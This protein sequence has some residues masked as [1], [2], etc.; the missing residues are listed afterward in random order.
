MQ[1]DPFPQ[2]ELPRF[3]DRSF[4]IVDFGA[5]ADGVTLNT[6]AINKAVRACSEAGGGTVIIPPGIWHTGPIQLQSNV[7]LRAER[8]ALVLFSRNFD[9]YPLVNTGFEGLRTVRCM[10]PIFGQRLENVAITGEGVFDGNGDAWRP[11]K[12]EKMTERQWQNLLASGGVTDPD[13]RIWYPTEVAYRG[14][15]IAKELIAKGVR[16][17]EAFKEARDFLRPT[18]LELDE[19]KRVLLDGPTFQN[20]A[21][22]CLHPW[23]CEHV[24]IRNVSVRNP[25]YSQ[26]GDGLDLESCRFAEVYNCRF[27]VGDDAICMKSGK[28]KDGREF[29]RPTEFVTVRDCIVYHGHGGFT[30]GSEMS[31]GVRNVRVF[32]CLF[33]GTDTGLRFKTARGRGGV[34]EKIDVRRIRMKDIPGPAVTFSMFYNLFRDP[35]LSDTAAHPVTEETPVFRDMYFEEIECVGARRAVEMAGLP[36]MPVQNVRFNGLNIVADRGI[37]VR[38]AKGV[39]FERA[40]VAVK[41]GPVFDAQ[42]SEDVRFEEV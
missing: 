32:D 29:G 26:N 34:V 7:N 6:E 24:T 23:A 33:I 16:D 31:G 38:F 36:E 40:R 21:A 37:F 20:S 11:V 14:G 22:W 30:I 39:S 18:L 28:D 4:S 5:K 9:D 10:S 8:G 3:P 13:G 1:L 2:V 17:P 19:C 35:R 42:E 41:E 25:W 15:A 27:D 12:K